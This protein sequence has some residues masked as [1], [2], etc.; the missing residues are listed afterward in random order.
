LK[1]FLSRFP[2]SFSRGFWLGL[3]LMTST[4]KKFQPKRAITVL[5][6]E[7]F[8]VKKVGGITWL[9]DDVIGAWKNLHGVDRVLL[10]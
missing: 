3:R 8:W 10:L 4:N 9:S 1:E 6:V 7:H 5:G 2:V